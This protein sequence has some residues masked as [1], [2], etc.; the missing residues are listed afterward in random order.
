REEFLLPDPLIDP[1][2]APDH[3]LYVRI[4]APWSLL[5]THQG[6]YDWSEV[7]RIVVPYRA[8]NYVVTLCLYGSNNAVDPAGL[9]PS[10]AHPA[11]LKAWLEFLRAA[12]L[13]FKGQVRTYEIWDA[14]NREGEWPADRVSDFAYMLKNS[15]VTVRSADPGALIAQGALALAGDTAES[16][17]A[18]QRALYAQDVATYVDVLPILLA[19]GARLAPLLERAYDLLL[20]NDPSG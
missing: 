4:R 15:S 3:P 17:L 5:E 13:H 10:A 6:T 12:A 16:D 14:P 11:V 2:I 18:W 8:A 20:Q 7:D 9:P 19:S 1:S